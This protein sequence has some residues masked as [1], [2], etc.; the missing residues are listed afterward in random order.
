MIILVAGA[1]IITSCNAGNKSNQQTDSAATTTSAT[2]ETPAAATSAAAAPKTFDINGV[3]VSDKPLGAFPYFNVPE[4]YENYEKNKIVD[5]DRF[6]I[7]TGDHFEDP[8]GKIFWSRITAKGDKAFSTLEVMKS[9]DELITGAGGVKVTEST[10]PQDSVSAHITEN[11]KLTYLS[12][13]GFMGYEPTTTYLVRRADRNIWVQLTP[14]DDGA[15]IGWAVVETKPFKQTATL[16][17]ADEMKKELDAKGHIA[18][19]INFDTDKATIKPESQPVIDEIKQLLTGNNELKVLI[20]GHTDNSG[21][22]AHNLKLSDDRA[23]SVKA[24]LTSAG[25][26]AARLQA[27]GLG[28]N[29]PVAD[30]GTEGGKAK[31]RRVEIVKI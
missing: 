25:I 4:G 27:K 23:K 21:T 5:Y 2:P 1:A 13:W 18:L 26:D 11:K 30:N 16:I 20:E 7:W 17:K 29:K 8:E 10:V 9:L 24:V 28:Q 15:S 6:H 3:P 19:Y 31:N 14:G 22:P 12:G